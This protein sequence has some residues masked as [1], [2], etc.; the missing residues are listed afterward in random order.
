MV[1]GFLLFLLKATG[2]VG[3]GFI[4]FLLIP[5]GSGFWS[6]SRFLSS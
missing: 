3:G 6:G 4:L 1:V 2:G 5:T